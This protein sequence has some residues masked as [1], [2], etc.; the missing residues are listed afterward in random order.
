M[1]KSSQHSEKLLFLNLKQNSVLVFDNFFYI[2]RYI[3]YHTVLACAH[4]FN[5][6]ILISFAFDE[7]LFSESSVLDAVN[8]YILFLIFNESL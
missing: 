3:K 2:L 8:I 7:F 6:T 5:L 4:Y 1:M